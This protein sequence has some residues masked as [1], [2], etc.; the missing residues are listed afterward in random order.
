MDFFMADVLLNF[1]LILT[2][3]YFFQFIIS[4]YSDIASRIFL[5]VLLGLAAILCMFFPMVSG[6]GFLWDLRW[7]ALLISILY[8]GMVSGGITATLIILVRFSLGGLQGALIALGVA[9]ALIIIFSYLRNGYQKQNFKRR[10]LASAGLGII[11]WG[12]A[13]TGI[14]IHFMLSQQLEQLQ[15]MALPVFSSMFILYVLSSMTF[16]YFSE[17]MR[18]YTTLKNEALMKEKVNYI[19]EV[20]EVIGAQLSQH[21]D[22]ATEHLYAMRKNA[23]TAEL[24]R[25]ESIE[26]ELMQV[27]QALSSYTAENEQIISKGKKPLVEVVDEVLEVLQPYAVQKGVRITVD[28]DVPATIQVD[29]PQM[30]TALVHLMRNGLDATPKN[31]HVTLSAMIKRNWLYV[32]VDDSGIGIAQEQLAGLMEVNYSAV[33]SIAGQGLRTTQQLVREM[34]GTFSITSEIQKGTT[35]TLKFPL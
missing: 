13:I 32:Y 10:I 14:V 30:K 21:L 33:N 20:G 19:T 12:V 34:E 8:G 7:I 5:G 23:S 15:E 1:L 28:I 11:A 25:I 3:L 18:H 4:S 9:I 22:R 16:I 27:S 31:G 29:Y 24:F 17:N 2:P 35:V 26:D 6:D